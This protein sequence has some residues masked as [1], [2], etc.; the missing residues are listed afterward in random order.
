MDKW[1]VI[2]IQTNND[3]T[4]G[5]FVFAYGD[6]LDAWE[7]FFDICKAAAK[8]QVLVHTCVILDN[9]GVIPEGGKKYFVHGVQ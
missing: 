4:V 2:E 7:K 5:N 8:S 9:K 1:L 3:G 6:E